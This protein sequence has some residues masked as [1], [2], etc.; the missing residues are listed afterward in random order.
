MK[1]ISVTIHQ[2]TIKTEATGYIGQACQGPIN[3]LL[4][5]LGGQINKEEITPEGMLPDAPI[6]QEADQEAFV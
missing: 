6:N 2:G 4:D 3:G 1:K 5:Q